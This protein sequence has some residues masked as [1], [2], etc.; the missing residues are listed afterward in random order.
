MNRYWFLLVISAFVVRAQA[1]SGDDVLLKAMADEMKHSMEI[2][3]PGPNPY[4]P[5]YMEYG[6]E[7][8]T[9]FNASA[10][11]GGLVRS[12][13]NQFFNPRVMVRVGNSKLDNSNSVY[14]GM[15]VGANYDS[16]Q[17]AYDGGYE[18]W[19][20]QYWLSTDRAYKSAVEALSRKVAALK[21]V[22]QGE[23]LNDFAPAKPVVKIMSEATLQLDEAKWKSRVVELSKIF[24]NYPEILHSSVD[25]DAISD[26][27]YYVNSEGSKQRLPEGAFHIR[28]RTLA[29]AAD[30]SNIWDYISIGAEHESGL[31]SMEEVKKAFTEIAENTKA[32]REAKVGEAY[33]GP[34]LFE[35]R[36]AGQLLVQMLSHE[37]RPVRS[38]VTPPGRQANL[39]PS[40]WSTRIGSRVLPDFITIKDNPHKLFPDGKPYLGNFDADLEGVEPEPLT[41][42]EKGTLKTQL[43]T[44]LPV[45]GHEGSNGRARFPGEFGAKAPFLSNVEV[46][47]S[48]AKPMAALKASL[49]D[50][51]KQRGKPYGILVR[52]LD[53][54]SVAPGE[55]RQRMMAAARQSGNGF[56]FSLPLQI[57]KVFPDGRE[58]LIRGVKFRGI[59]GRSLRDIVGA[60]SETSLFSFYATNV[61]LSTGGG[62]GYVNGT[63][64]E[65]PGLLFDELELEQPQNDKPRLP[66]VAP[67]AYEASN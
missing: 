56:V 14:T 40:D 25:F 20:Q 6:A 46:Y 10:T 36:A 22:N 32:L 65:S 7:R 21:D 23:P 61:P 24:L 35:P 4:P 17:W 12:Q 62:G 15:A 55:D 37:L 48:D 5:Y 42:I 52:K 49:I 57:Y 26:T 45:R 11:L 47:V 66:I 27:A 43:H 34:V 1:P 54:P 33:T 9:T 39:P 2:R 18:L 29:Q 41:L 59:T 19:R 67:P 16:G 13:K 51:I 44:R 53:Y 58:E 31:P 3:I 63:S 30:G 50:Q 8:S 38:P 64:I 28:A 60:S